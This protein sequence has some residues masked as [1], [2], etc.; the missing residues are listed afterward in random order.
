MCWPGERV[1]L[2][3][4]MG[5][6]VPVKLGVA[7]ECAELLGM[8]TSVPMQLGVAAKCAGPATKCGSVSVWKRRFR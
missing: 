1:R 2:H 6:S 7:A 5:T 3:V 8:E 4:E